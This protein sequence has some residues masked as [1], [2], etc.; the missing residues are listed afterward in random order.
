[1]GRSPGS[2]SKLVADP[3]RLPV[4]ATSCRAT[5]LYEM[6]KQKFRNACNGRFLFGSY[7]DDYPEVFVTWKDLVVF[8]RSKKS[9]Q[10]G[11]G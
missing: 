6:V 2:L 8:R 10:T 11:T 4:D 7:R 3:R 9:G 5:G 1:M